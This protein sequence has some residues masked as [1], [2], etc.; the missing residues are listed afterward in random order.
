MGCHPNVKVPAKKPT[1]LTRR[2]TAR[3]SYAGN[4]STERE[5]SLDESSIRRK[6]SDIAALLWLKNTSGVI[7][8]SLVSSQKIN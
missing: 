6:S 1:V 2:T 7:T 3:G 5:I 8:R 4:I